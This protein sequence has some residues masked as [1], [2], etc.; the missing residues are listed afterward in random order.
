MLVITA[1]SGSG[2]ADTLELVNNGSPS[3]NAGCPVGFQSNTFCGNVTMR[4]FYAG[5]SLNN[6]YLQVTKIADTNDADLSGHAGVNSDGSFGTPSIARVQ[7][8]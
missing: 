2:P 6:A 5:R 1:I 8:Q 7:I 3:T 4:S